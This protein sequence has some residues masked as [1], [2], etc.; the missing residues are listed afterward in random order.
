MRIFIPLSDVISTESTV[1]SSIISISFFTY[2]KSIIGL[3]RVAPKRRDRHP[4]SISSRVKAREDCRAVRTEEHVVLDPHAAPPRPID[5]RLDRH[6]RALGQRALGRARQPR[7][8]VHLQAEPV[9]EA[10]AEQVPVAALLNVVARDGVGI[11]ARHS[12]SDARAPRSRWRLRTTSY[13]SRCSSVGAA[14]DERARHVGTVPARFRTEVEQQEVAVL[15]AATR[16]TR[17]RKRR[18]R[19]RRDDRRE[20]KPFAAFVAQCLLEHAGDLELRHAGAGPAKSCRSS[21]RV[22]I[23]F[24]ASNQRELARVLSLAQRFDE[25]DGRTP[26][27]ARAR[28]EQPLKIAMQQVSRLE[29]DDF[30]MRES[31]IA[32]A[33]GRPTDSAARC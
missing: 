8:F 10:V 16:R 7:S 13:T 30:E 11:P 6:H 21:A 28:F 2:R 24:A 12:G 27:P 25:I 33:T 4:S 17:V 31:A 19:P 3:Y 20:R 15:D 1:D 32:A 18:A 14:D 9:A 26:L 22:A 23:P 5:P 29:A